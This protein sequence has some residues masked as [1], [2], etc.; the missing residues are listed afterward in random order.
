M[1]DTF[2]EIFELL[3]NVHAPIR[4][5][6]VSPDFAPWLTPDLRKLTETR[7][8]LKKIAVKSSEMWSAYTKQRKGDTKE[9]KYYIQ[10]Y[11]KGLIEKS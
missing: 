6:R 10:D 3:L 1:A 8:R 5:R 11:Y 4:K 9:I 2:Q 7:N